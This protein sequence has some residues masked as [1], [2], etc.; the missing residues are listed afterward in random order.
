MTHDTELTDF[1]DQRVTPEQKTARVGEVFHNVAARYDVMND[2]M[3]LGTHRL[4]KRL[5]V[6]YSAV[7]PGHK[8][9]DLAGGTG[10]LSRLLVPHLGERGEIVLADMNTAMLDQA[11]D[12]LL[13]IGITKVRLVQADAADLPMADATFDVVV[14][15]F[16]LRNFTH[17]TRALNEIQRV[18]TPGGRLLVLEFSQPE[19]ALLKGAFRAYMNLWPHLGQLVVGQSQPYRYLV[20]SIH[21]YPNARTV[22][23]MMQ[24]ARLTKV[25][26]HSLLG[27]VATLHIGCKAQAD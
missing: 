15:A 2:L 3:S 18:L 27:G 21:Q 4:L 5:L 13:D 1:G 16:G 17:K 26:Y 8:V 24:D 22:S 23:L 7:R 11:R 19:N 10:D 25:R 6:Y 9:L 20:E 14:V 12:R